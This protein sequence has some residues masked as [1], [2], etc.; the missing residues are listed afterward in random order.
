MPN[1]DYKTEY[2]NPLD[3]NDIKFFD[4]KEGD[5]IIFPSYLIHRAPI[6]KNDIVKTIISFNLDVGYPD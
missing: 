2:I 1:N 6:V 4:I 5:L 3:K